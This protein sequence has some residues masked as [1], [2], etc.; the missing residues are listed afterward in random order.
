MKGILSGG[1]ENDRKSDLPTT[2]FSTSVVGCFL[3][4]GFLL[5]AKRKAR[6]APKVGTTYDKHYRGK[7]YRLT[8]VKADETVGFKLG[9]EVFK[10]PSGAAKSITGNEIN[11]WAF[12]GIE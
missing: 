12:W 2:G 8:V 3:T 1:Y 5:M 7:Q 6:E 4:K 9:N 10:T 11:G